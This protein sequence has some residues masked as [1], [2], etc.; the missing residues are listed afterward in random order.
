MRHHK[1]LFVPL[2]L[3]VLGLI[4]PAT[5]AQAPVAMVTDFSGAGEI[6]ANGEASTCEILSYLTIDDR[7]RLSAGA[8][9]TLVYFESSQEYAFSGPA[10]LAIGADAPSLISG[11]PPKRKRQQLAERT[12]LSPHAVRGYRQTSLVLRGESR[13]KL[14]LLT[15]KNTSIVETHPVFRWEPIAENA[16]Y[17]FVL[18]NDVGRTLVKVLITTPELRLGK[19]IPMERGAFYTWQVDATLASGAT[20]SSSADF[21]VLTQDQRTQVESLRPGAS[22]T[23]TERVI[24]AEYLEQTDL[25]EQAQAYWKALAAERPDSALLQARSEK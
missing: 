12:S 17:R 16:H 3:F 5:A 14:R 1:T 22:A 8:S 25:V 15:P 20:Y 11:A 2:A 18:T 10:E 23:F 19:E 7:V 21:I 24:Y 13:N 6:T 4:G 9:L